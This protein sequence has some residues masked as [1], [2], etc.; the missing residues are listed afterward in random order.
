[1]FIN[2]AD[3]NPEILG[4]ALRVKDGIIPPLT[5][6]FDKG[7]KPF[8]YFLGYGLYVLLFQ[9]N[10]HIYS[11]AVRE[12]HPVYES[13]ICLEHWVLGPVCGGGFMRRGLSRLRH[14]FEARGDSHKIKALYSSW[15]SLL[16]LLTYPVQDILFRESQKTIQLEA[17]DCL[18]LRPL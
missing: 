12:T 10:L 15:D 17:E 8:D 18:L 6:G 9:V 4:Q 13:R 16:F 14:G 3:I 2:P 5:I 7:P 1:L 11:F